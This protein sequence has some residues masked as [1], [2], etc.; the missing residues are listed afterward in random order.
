MKS[1]F[2]TILL[3]GFT[4]SV[5]SSEVGL[6]LVLDSHLELIN[7][8]DEM[9]TTVFNR[10]R[11]KVVRL[12]RTFGFVPVHIRKALRPISLGGFKV[13]RPSSKNT[14][15]KR[16]TIEFINQAQQEVMLEALRR[17]TG[18]ENRGVSD[19]GRKLEAGNQQAQVYILAELKKYGLDAKLDCYRDRGFGRECN[20][21]ADLAG[22][23]DEII[24][25]QGHLDDVGHE[26]AGADDNASGSSALLAM[27]Q[28]ISGS[29]FQ[30]TIR[31]LFTNGE[32][33]GLV[34]SSS[35]VRRLKATGE[36]QRIKFTINMDM[37][38]YNRNSIFEI[39]TNREFEQQAQW[40]AELAHTYTH[41]TPEI[42]IPAWGSDHEVFLNEGIPSVLTIEDWQTKTPCRHRACDKI[43][44]L[45]INYAM[46]IIRLNLAAV[47]ELAVLR[48]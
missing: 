33:A 11:V 9:T 27:A 30:K 29:R 21:V 4:I 47:A 20:V 40:Y 18:F 19:L 32:E 17:L 44:T 45:N 36:L 8:V 34:G 35:Y 48:R 46:E 41:L 23:T 24:L 43:E 26:K 42:T 6:F 1:I 31:F 37:V 25:V 13:Y 2:T 39:E 22:E 12:K 38:A 10:G 14:S 28:V 15:A 5:L 3:F 7:D 16:P